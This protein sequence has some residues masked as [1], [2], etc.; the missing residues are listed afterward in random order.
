MLNTVPAG[1][2][3]SSPVGPRPWITKES[4]LDLS[5]SGVVRYSGN[6]TTQSK[7]AGAAPATASYV[8][9]SSSGSTLKSGS[10]Q[11]GRKSTPFYEA[12]QLANLRRL[13]KYDRKRCS[14]G[15]IWQD[16]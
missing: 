1:T 9:L 15:A 6:I 3:L 8:F 12:D 7:A 14:L 5:P 11:A 13:A 10:S 16:H 4:H 2:T